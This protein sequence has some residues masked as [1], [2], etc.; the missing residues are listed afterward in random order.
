MGGA[1]AC[2]HALLQMR[3]CRGTS[4][5]RNSQPPLDHHRTLD[6]VLLQD[7][8]EGVFLMSEVPVDM[9]EVDRGGVVTRYSK[10]ILNPEYLIQSQILDLRI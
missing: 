10:N 2:R 4:L 5:I 7:P 6:V 9:D 3:P 1:L 8:R